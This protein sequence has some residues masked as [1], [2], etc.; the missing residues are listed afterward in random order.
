MSWICFL[1]LIILVH[2]LS[3]VYLVILTTF[4]LFEATVHQISGFELI[5]SSR[6]GIP[7]NE[8]LLTEQ[9]LINSLG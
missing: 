1:D 7:T 5:P 3:K 2:I 9:T 8:P 6:S 4:A